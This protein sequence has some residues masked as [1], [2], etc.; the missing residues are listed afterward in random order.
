M[1]SFLFYYSQVF[2]SSQGHKRKK[3]TKLKWMVSRKNNPKQSK[4]TAHKHKKGCTQS[5]ENQTERFVF[6]GIFQNPK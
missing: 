2:S 4:D 5:A 1:V 6:V 3:N